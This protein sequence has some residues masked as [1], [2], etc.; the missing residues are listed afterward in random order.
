MCKGWKLSYGGGRRSGRSVGEIADEVEEEK[1]LEN[2]EEK[3]YRRKVLV[4]T[5]EKKERYRL[6]GGELV[7]R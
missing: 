1:E 7:S 5:E 2:E 6:V 3:M 4:W